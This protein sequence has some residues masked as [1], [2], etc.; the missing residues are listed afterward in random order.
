LLLT[1]LFTTLVFIIDSLPIAAGQMV[2]F[3][4]LGIAGGIPPKKIFP[5]YKLLL[6]LVALVV[7]LQVLFGGGLSTGLMIS[8]RIVALTV[9]MPLLT[10]T[11]EARFLA[12]GITRLGANYRAAYIITSTLNLIPSFEEEA[13]LIIDARRLRGVSSL[14]TGNVF[15]R[16]R[17][18]PSIVLPLMIKAMRQAQI[19]GL[20]M[21][22]RAFGAFKT[23]TWL[24]GTKFSGIDYRAFAAGIFYSVIAVTANYMV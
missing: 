15:K 16:L 3:V 21:D 2:F 8:C 19:L 20:A 5:H 6:F 7:A 9:L 4:A 22:A 18:Y 12:L 14:E 23:R 13:R 24:Q 17:E 11:T 10:M 1:T